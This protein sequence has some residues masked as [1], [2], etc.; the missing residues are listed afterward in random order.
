[1]KLV[2]V[3][4]PIGFAV[5][6]AL[7]GCIDGDET[8]TLAGDGSG[9]V[10]L[11]FTLDLSFV[12][13]LKKLEPDV[14]GEDAEDLT[15]KIDKKMIQDSVTGPG[16]KVGTLDVEDAGPKKHVKLE[17]EFKDL[18]ALRALSGFSD[19]RLDFAESGDNVDVTYRFFA[20]GLYG[21][22]GIGTEEGEAP[23]TDTD[24]KMAAIVA[25]ATKA[26]GGRFTLVLPG[27]VLAT[28]GKA[29]AGN[30]KAAFFE[31]PKNDPA[32]QKKLKKEP[33]V[34]TAA[35]A[36]K[37]APF[38]EK[39]KARKAAEERKEQER[40]EKPKKAPAPDDD[41]AGAPPPGKKAPGKPGGE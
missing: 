26:A 14:G 21:F 8:L 39:E 35:I 33:F 23:A 37:D 20:T 30:E 6:L 18:E 11:D 25:D 38:F 29:V 27:K 15:K 2:R 13:K 1:M 17:L 7:G 34:M 5:L 24:K 12:E 10:K 19:R 40:K 9:T 22:A 4:A 41:D 28:S 36:K 3:L 16:V 31:I 32:L